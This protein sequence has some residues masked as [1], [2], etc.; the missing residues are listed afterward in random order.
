MAQERT[1]Y[2]I[3]SRGSQLALYQAEWVKARLTEAHPGFNFPVKV[4]STSGDAV[5][6]RPLHELGGKGVFTKEIEDALIA[7]EID[8]AVHS[9]KDVPT[10][11]PP[12]LVLAAITRREDA[13]D[14][15][16]PHP[17][18]SVRTLDGLSGGAVVATGSLRRRAQ[19]LSWGKGL[20]VVDLR[21]NLAT[22]FSKLEKSDWA[23]MILAKAGV[24]RLG[25]A[26]RIGE[27]IDIERMVP[28]PGQGALGIEVRAGEPDVE[29]VLSVIVSEATT[30]A[31]S[32]ERAFLA[33]LEGGCKV[34]IGAYGR[35]EDGTLHLEGLVASVDGA[36]VYRGRVS[37]D[38]SDAAGLGD[39]LAGT[40]LESGAGK[41]LEGVRLL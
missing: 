34:P 11:L 29:A 20:N 10:E 14:V 9:L 17:K 31:T 18:A 12:G 7:R 30:F 22:R 3:G 38:P 27:T 8:L 32:A 37:G 28:A 26:D 5:L 2:V 23:G 15:F 40:L 16:I 19:L 24:L 6:D 41:A 39:R 1:K 35:I 13:R 33:R 21:G 4:I 25:L 36:L